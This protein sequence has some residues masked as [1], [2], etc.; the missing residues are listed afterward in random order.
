MYKYIT[1]V[2]VIVIL[3]IVIKKYNEFFTQNPNYTAISK[4]QTSEDWNNPDFKKVFKYLNKDIST[5]NLEESN[6]PNLLPVPKIIFESYDSCPNLYNLFHSIKRRDSNGKQTRGEGSVGISFRNE[7]ERIFYNASFFVRIEHPIIEI[8][9]KD[10]VGK[11]NMILKASNTLQLDYNPGSLSPAESYPPGYICDKENDIK[12]LNFGVTSD[13]TM[14]DV[15]R[16]VDF[17]YTQLCFGMIYIEQMKL[18]GNHYRVFPSP[19]GKG[20][21]FILPERIRH[22][23]SKEGKYYTRAKCNTSSLNI[24]VLFGERMPEKF[25]YI[26]PNSPSD[27]SANIIEHN[28]DDYI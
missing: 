28:L 15:L 16:F 13:F 24:I 6:Y 8:E 22:Q 14:E 21:F 5:L 19:V 27:C 18:M 17:S 20:S 25:D 4:Y 11:Q 26:Y 9:G 7:C 10:V 2:L 23:V 3:F 1:L 12:Q